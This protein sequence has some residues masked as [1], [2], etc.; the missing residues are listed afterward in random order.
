M[1]EID[2]DRIEK[3]VL[4]FSILLPVL[5]VAFL[6][7]IKL[8][9]FSFG[10][11]FTQFGLFPR[12][13]QGIAGIFTAPLIHADFE[14][15]ASNSIP[16]IVGA[17]CI[18]IFYRPIA[19]QVLLW[20]YMMTGLWV[21]AAGREVLHIGASGLVYGFVCFVFFSGIFRWDKRLL[22]P[23]LFMIVFFGTMIWGVFPFEPLISWESHALGSLAGI[24][25]AFFFRKD[26]PQREKYEWEEEA[27]QYDENGMPIEDI[28]FEVI[29]PEPDDRPAQA[30]PASPVRY[31]Y[32]ERKS[33]DNTPPQDPTR[34]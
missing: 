23:S 20:I 5:F 18:L 25:T 9:E 16:L 4:F 3:K 2:S 11:S 29:H 28:S 34:I 17:A 26:G 14:H 19:M 6:W 31:I 32:I 10:V 7:G 33:G 21:W 13:L 15:L 22:R 24:I 27:A 1:A 30:Q 8:F 12:T